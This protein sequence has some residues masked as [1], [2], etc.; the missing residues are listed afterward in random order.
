MWGTHLVYHV[1]KGLSGTVGEVI[2]QPGLIP[3]R[4]NF[5]NPW[6]VFVQ[7]EGMTV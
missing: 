6:G 2:G 5:L 1:D 7:K 4:D 3:A